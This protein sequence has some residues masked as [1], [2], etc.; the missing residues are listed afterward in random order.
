[1]A[2]PDITQLL[3]SSIRDNFQY[4]LAMTAQ[5]QPL[6]PET[7]VV[8]RGRPEREPGGA[9]IGGI[10]VSTTF[11]AGGEYIYGRS[12][13]DTWEDLEAVLGALEAGRALVFSSGMSAISATFDLLPPKGVIVAPSSGYMNTS[14]QLRKLE[15]N[16]RLIIRWVDITDTESVVR[17]LD[18]AAMLFFES[19]VNPLPVSYTHLTLPTSP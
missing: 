1:V 15:A 8:L 7:E 12:D 5:N 16:G 3:P 19:P 18:G 14:V 2:L 13:N 4:D 11:R 6:H 9:I 10:S 17:A